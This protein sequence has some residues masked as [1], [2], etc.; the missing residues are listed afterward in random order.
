MV[1]DHWRF[2]LCM[3]YSDLP[4]HGRFPVAVEL[5][6]DS[7]ISS[8]NGAP[9]M[10]PHGVPLPFIDDPETSNSINGFRLD[11]RTTK[12]IAA[13]NRTDSHSIQGERIGAR[14]SQLARVRIL[15]EVNGEP[16]RHPVA[17]Y[18]ARLRL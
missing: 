2:Q 17:N 18:P 8:N 4:R 3:S 5:G 7:S 10:L 1:I 9:S 14:F 13:Y 11:D 6:S 12:S 16:S 15:L